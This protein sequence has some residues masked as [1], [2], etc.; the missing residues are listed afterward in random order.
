M[1]PSFPISP[2]ISGSKEHLE[3]KIWFTLTADAPEISFGYYGSRQPTSGMVRR[4]R[5]PD[6]TH[7]DIQ[8]TSEGSSRY[9]GRV[10]VAVG[11]TDHEFD[12]LPAEI[13]DAVLGL[14]RSEHEESAPISSV[15]VPMLRDF[16]NGRNGYGDLSA[17]LGEPG[18]ADQDRIVFW[19]G[20][21]ESMGA[22]LGRVEGLGDEYLVVLD[23][24]E[25]SDL[26]AE[27]EEAGLLEDAGIGFKWRGKTVYRALGRLLELTGSGFDEGDEP[28]SS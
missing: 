9:G 4:T 15:G 25:F 16:K 8:F 20:D 10:A 28:L 21:G 7:T 23:E 19:S 18:T 13:L 12:R 17:T 22:L 3:E 27:L 11:Y 6:T 1:Q 26:A 14:L 24:V 2:L 5:T